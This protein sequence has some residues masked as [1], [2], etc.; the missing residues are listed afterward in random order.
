LLKKSGLDASKLKNYCPV[1]NLSFLSKLL[2]SVVLC[3]LPTF[4]DSNDLMPK[5]QSAYHRIHST[6]TAVTK[7][8]NDLLF[9]ADGGQMSGL[10][11]LDL[12]AAFDTVD[13]TLLL[14]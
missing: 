1:S 11:L 9:A 13:H 3:R 12:T 14:D 2:E 4:L 8:F 10:C 7:I 5:T 6:E